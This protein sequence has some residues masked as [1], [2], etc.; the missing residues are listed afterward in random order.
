MKRE[1]GI[2][3]C[4]AQILADLPSL[5]DAFVHRFVERVN[6]V[7]RIAFGSIHCDIGIRHQFFRC[8][9]MLWV[10]GNADADPRLDQH[11]PN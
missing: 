3:Q 5:A 1:I 2:L 7:Q 4:F 11:V 8:T 10:D 9:A 6:P